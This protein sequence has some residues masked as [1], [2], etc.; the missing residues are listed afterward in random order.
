MNLH[1]G[2]D[3]RIVGSPRRLVR[4][5]AALLAA[6]LSVSAFTIALPATAVQPGSHV[7]TVV[8]DTPLTNT[9]HVLDG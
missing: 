3:V 1:H 2:D 8:R 7:G 9:P 6:L 5:V 4:H